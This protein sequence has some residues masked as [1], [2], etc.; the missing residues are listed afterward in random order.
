LLLATPISGPHRVYTVP[1]AMRVDCA[2][3]VLQTVS[4][5]APRVCAS[6]IASSVSTVSPDCAIEITSVSGPTSASR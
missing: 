6:C 3:G 2:P 4:S 5:L 1:S